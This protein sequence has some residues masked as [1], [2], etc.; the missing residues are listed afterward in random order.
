MGNR[1]SNNSHEVTLPRTCT[2]LPQS[3]PSVTIPYHYEGRILRSK[4][5][6]GNAQ[7]RYFQALKTI[8]RTAIS[9]TIPSTKWPCAGLVAWL[10]MCDPTKQTT[11]NAWAV[12]VICGQDG[13]S[14]LGVSFWAAVQVR[15]QSIHR[16]RQIGK[17]CIVRCLP[18]CPLTCPRDGGNGGV[19]SVG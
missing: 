10:A 17:V 7:A 8:K 5:D 2:C 16:S 4:T 19:P 14:P 15:S 18:E 9:G 12:W 6:C 11:V 3:Q 1:V 13:S